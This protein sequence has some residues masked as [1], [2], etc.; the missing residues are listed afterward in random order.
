MAM[1]PISDAELV[2]KLKEMGAIKPGG[3]YADFC[4]EVKSEAEEIKATWGTPQGTTP[5]FVK[6]MVGDLE[7]WAAGKESKE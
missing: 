1:H 3:S 5:D 7:D 4:A 6:Q 2:E